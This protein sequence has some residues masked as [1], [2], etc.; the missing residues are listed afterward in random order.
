MAAS[1]AAGSSR[2][3][4]MD[5]SHLLERLHLE[6]DALDNLVWEEE[7]EDE[8]DQTKWLALARVLTEKNSA[9]VP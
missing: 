5:P 9:R 7:V 2:G 4:R 1:S 6:E 8:E 3:E